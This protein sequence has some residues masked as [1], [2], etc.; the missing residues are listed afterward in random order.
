VSRTLPAIPAAAS[1]ASR[2]LLLYSRAEV[3][4]LFESSLGEGDGATAAH[5]VHEEWMRG[6]MAMHIELALEK[7]WQHA[8][9]SIPEW[10][11]MRHVHWLAE[12]YEVA[13]RFRASR[14]RSN[15]YLVLLDYSDSRSEPYGIYVGMSHYP[16][17]VRFD[18]HKAG[19]RAAGSVLK[20]GLEVLH[21]PTLH[22]QHIKRAQAAVIEER[23][24]EALTAEGLFVQGGH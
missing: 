2:P 13:K 9:A 14:G 22:L 18:Q 17:A 19:I 4:A 3:S 24:A 20:R 11:P 10:L 7:L 6:A 5:C 15:I 23:L 8:A 16:P 21:G 12:V 1:P